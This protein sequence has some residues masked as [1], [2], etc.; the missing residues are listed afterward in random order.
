[1]TGGGGG[2]GDSTRQRMAAWDRTCVF[3]STEVDFFVDPLIIGIEIT[4]F[5][6][7]I[8]YWSNYVIQLSMFNLLSTLVF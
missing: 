7:C 3:T 4:Y 2:G 6:P 5:L 1:M 8:E